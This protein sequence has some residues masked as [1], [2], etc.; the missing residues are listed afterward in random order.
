MIK[1]KEL[2]EASG[3]G[4]FDY[5][6]VINDKLK[7]H[8][9]ADNNQT[10]AGASADAPDAKFQ[11]GGVE[12]N[13]EIKADHKAMFGQIELKHDGEKWDVSERSKIK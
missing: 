7:K 3:Q 10:T 11:H 2:T 8:G 6:K 12:H 13:I 1:F 4:G 5:E 9:K